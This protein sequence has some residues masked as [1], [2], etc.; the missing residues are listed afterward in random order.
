[1]RSFVI[2]TFPYALCQELFIAEKFVAAA[3]NP[4]PLS[5]NISSVLYLSA[6]TPERT[7]L[8]SYIYSFVDHL[9]LKDL[10]AQLQQSSWL[11]TLRHK[12]ADN[13]LVTNSVAQSYTRCMPYR[14]QSCIAH[15]ANKCTNCHPQVHEF[16]LVGNA[17]IDVGA[18]VQ[19]ICLS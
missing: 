14:F 11:H 19:N 16:H 12:A 5:R 18:K 17:L 10:D 15:T 3:L 4:P 8:S 2:K 9:S 1:M 7:R 13:I 6:N